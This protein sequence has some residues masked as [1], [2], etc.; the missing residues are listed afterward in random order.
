MCVPIVEEFS[1]D[2]PWGKGGKDPSGF[3]RRPR[4]W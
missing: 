4:G 2:V 3:F 1:V